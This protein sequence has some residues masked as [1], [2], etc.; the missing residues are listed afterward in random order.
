[1][2]DRIWLDVPFSQKDPAKAADARWDPVA[3]R[4][5]A[6]RPGITGLAPWLAKPPVP[7]LLPG[8]D[9][10][11]GTGLFVDL[12]PQTCWFTN[13]RSCVSEQCQQSRNPPG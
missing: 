5:Y 6:P 1:M 7:Q 8:E 9:R 10:T 2:S 3:R 4:W 13:V 11:L 12:V